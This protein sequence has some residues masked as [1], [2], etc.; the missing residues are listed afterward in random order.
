MSLKT[1]LFDCH[2]AAGGKMV[3]FAGY[4]LPIHYGSLVNEHKAVRQTAGVFDV[5]H[6]T[7]V[8]VTGVNAEAWLRYL[9]TNDVKKLSHGQALYSCMCRE[10]GGVLDDLIVYQI[11]DNSYRVI[12]NAATREKDLEWF[13]EQKW[14]FTSV[15]VMD[16]LAL[17]AVQGPQAVELASEVLEEFGVS[18]ETT[19]ALKRFSAWQ[20]RDWFVA[21]TG[22]T[23]EDG[24][25]IA[26][27]KD[28]AETFW[29]RLLQRGVS[30]AGLGAR[31]TLRL[32]A[33]MSLY[34]NDLDEQHSPV[35]SGIAWTVDVSDSNRDFIGRTVL[36]A[37]KRSGGRFVQV[38][39]TLESRGVL[40]QGQVVEVDGESVGVITSGTF[41]PTLQKTIALARVN[42][43]IE[44]GCD[45]L[46]RDKPQAA[47]V[48]SVPFLTR[49]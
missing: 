43:P 31:D 24:L 4:Q 32:E 23:G 37:Q 41:S 44:S 46:I 35:E 27:P 6:M 2:V 47:R 49:D 19:R 7:I 29:E 16:D 45:V 26:L 3:D 48:I 9:F 22:Y 30:P 11:G 10:N 33:G 15:K 38:G 36:E 34:G 8:D 28:S 13:A 40:R 17:V 14:E 42:G 18:G 25:E 5:S 20:H 21:R 39:L 1:P 12:V